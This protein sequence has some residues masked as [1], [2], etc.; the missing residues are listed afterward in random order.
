MTTTPNEIIWW[1]RDHKCPICKS[2]LNQGDIYTY[3]SQYYPTDPHHYYT[4]IG[5]SSNVDCDYMVEIEFDD[6]K[7]IILRREEFWI[8]ND[9]YVFTINIWHWAKQPNTQIFW[10][11]S[12]DSDS[13]NGKMI[14]DGIALDLENFDK[15]KFCKQLEMLMLFQ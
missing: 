12:E 2:P 14:L 1:A 4:E 8:E 6:P 13:A 11:D 10:A 9:K 7:K 5:C 15:E 3:D